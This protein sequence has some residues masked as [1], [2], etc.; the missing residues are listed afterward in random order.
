MGT[1][2]PRVDAYIE[3]AAPFARPLLKAMRSA[4]HGGAP[5]VQETI[6]WG[7]PFFLHD[8][9]IMA[10]MAGFKQHCALG[11]WHGREA[12]DRGLDG[13]AMGQFGRLR[14]RADLPPAAELKTLVREV[15]ARM[16]AGAVMPRAP[17]AGAVKVKAAATRPPPRSRSRPG[18]A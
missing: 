8:G 10:Y 17:K 15:A 3:A 12:A 14:E 5:R 16:E 1:K 4:I 9:R 7:M 6:K 11:F 2:D 13:Q 18:P